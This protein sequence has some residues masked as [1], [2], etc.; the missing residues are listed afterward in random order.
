MLL[1][2]LAETKPSGYL[3]WFRGQILPAN[4]LGNTYDVELLYEGMKYVVEVTKS[5]PTSF[6]LV[7]ADSYKEVEVHRMSD[8]GLLMSIDGSS[9]TTYMKEEVDR[10]RIIIG[11]QTCVFEKQN[12]PSILR[13]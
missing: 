10:Y 13:Y 8:G 5:S 11:N 1:I 3:S 7:M 12:D 2:S 4:T 9:Y 6:F